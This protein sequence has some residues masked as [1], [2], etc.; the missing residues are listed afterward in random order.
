MLILYCIAGLGACLAWVVGPVQ[1]PAGGWV[2]SAV[3][4]ALL[5]PDQTAGIAWSVEELALSD[6]QPKV[7]QRA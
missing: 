3:R 1:L 5:V 2:L 4:Y 6:I 7:L